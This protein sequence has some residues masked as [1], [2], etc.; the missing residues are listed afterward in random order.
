VATPRFAVRFLQPLTVLLLAVIALGAFPATGNAAPRPPA[1]PTPQTSAE[2]RE[3]LSHISEQAE[4]VSEKYN[5]ATVTLKKRRAE[6]RAADRQARAIQRQYA[7]LGGQ[8]KRVVSAA[9]MNVPFG[10]LTMMLTS[11]SPGDF[12]EQLSTLRLLAVKR[13]TLI[14]KVAQVR[15][16]AL[17]AQSRAQAALAAAQKVS[18]DM[19]ARDADLKRKKVQ[20]ETL[21]QRLSTQ[22]RAALVSSASTTLRASRSSPRQPAPTPT[23]GPASGAAKLAVQRALDQIGD[24]YSWGAAGPDA[25]D[26][27]G[28]TMYSWAAAGVALPHSSS[29]QYG[30]GVH[31]SR[32][33]VAAGDLVFFYSPIHHVGIAINNSQ[34][35]HAPTYGQPVQIANIDSSPYVGATRVG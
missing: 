27:S 14:D 34:M 18:R 5:D 33:Q 23:V 22:E 7:E 32:S 17:R 12:V 19:A 13:G 30:V 1:P 16:A 2:A 26:C 8:L 15:V 6:Y 21:V 31:I 29:A 3:Q 25:F 10:Q 11:R 35:V 24:P 28:L 20:L 9:Y 4:I